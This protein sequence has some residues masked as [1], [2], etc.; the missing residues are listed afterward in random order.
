MAKRLQDLTIQLSAPHIQTL[1]PENEAFLRG[2]RGEAALDSVREGWVTVGKVI[3]VLGAI[4]LIAVIA[5]IG[6]F[7]VWNSPLAVETEGIV[8]GQQ[9]NNVSYHYIVDGVRYDKVEDS[10]RLSRS[11]WDEGNS[12]YPIIYLSFQPQISR[13]EHN[14]EKVEWFPMIFLLGIAASIPAFGVYT[15]RFTRR[16]IL[17]RDEA[18][19]LLQGEIYRSF[20]GQKGAVN[21]LYTATSPITG[22]KIGGSLTIGRLNSR[23]GRIQTGSMVAILY[24]NDKLHT[25]L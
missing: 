24:K 23:F 1:R 2:E 4:A 21:Y 18:T 3:V 20:R 17:L 5:L 22:K 10:S 14:V 6:V 16:M 8:E 25:V 15:I 7:I 19:H 9:G 11:E 12:P 13:L